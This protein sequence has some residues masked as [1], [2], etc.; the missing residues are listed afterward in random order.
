L[1]I[2]LTGLLKKTLNVKAPSIQSGYGIFFISHTGKRMKPDS[3]SDKIS[4]FLYKPD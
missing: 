1:G 2:P 3:M 4:L